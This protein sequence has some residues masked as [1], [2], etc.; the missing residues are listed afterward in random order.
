M[1]GTIGKKRIDDP[2]EDIR[3]LHGRIINP[4][5]KEKTNR[6]TNDDQPNTVHPTD[7]Y[8]NAAAKHIKLHAMPKGVTHVRLQPTAQLDYEAIPSTVTHL[9]FGWCNDS[10]VE[11]GM[12][13]N[14]IKCLILGQFGR[15]NLKKGMI[16]ESVT[17][18]DLGQYR[19][20]IRKCH[21]PKKLRMLK[22]YVLRHPLKPR[23]LPIGLK[24]IYFIGICNQPIGPGV[25]PDTVT[26]IIFGDSFNQKFV[27]EYF[28]EGLMF[29]KFGKRFDQ[30]LDLRRFHAL[31]ALKVD[32]HYRNAITEPILIPEMVVV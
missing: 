29:L 17:E 25:I 20:L 6:N 9:D 27:P 26:H 31:R 1:G 13:P 28:P 11:V 4:R 10:N 23:V 3:P 7:V 15:I 12:I 21:L 16:P 19:K 24:S 22:I 30:P 5:V 8:F 18:L 14:S 32:P 2:P